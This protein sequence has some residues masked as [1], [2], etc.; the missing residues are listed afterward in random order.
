MQSAIYMVTTPPWQSI[1][2]GVPLWPT[3]PPTTSTWLP[4]SSWAP[5]LFPHTWLSPHHVWS[6]CLALYR[7]SCFD[8]TFIVY[9][10]IPYNHC[11]YHHQHHYRR[12]RR[13]LG[14]GDGKEECMNSHFVRGDKSSCTEREESFIVGV[15]TFCRTSILRQNNLKSHCTN[16]VCHT[17]DIFTSSTEFS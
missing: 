7:P 15:V 14:A 1:I 8:Y 13:W 11:C 3:D 9:V 16:F 10:T 12:R 4:S 6:P 2:L 5:P 17:K